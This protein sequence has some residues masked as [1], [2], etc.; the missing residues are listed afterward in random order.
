MKITFVNLLALVFVVLKLTHVIDWSWPWVLS[1][2]W[3]TLI[4]AFVLAFLAEL[5]KGRGQ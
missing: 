3:I 1:P 5:A 4:I 2:I